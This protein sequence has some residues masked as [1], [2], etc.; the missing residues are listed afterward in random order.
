MFTHLSTFCD[1]SRRHITCHRAQGQTLDGTVSV[2]LGLENPDAR[3]PSDVASILYVA[4]TR[5]RRLQD[6]FVSPIFP[7]FWKKIAENQDIDRRQSEMA[8]RQ[9]SADLA[10]KYGMY[11]EMR[12]ELDWRPDYGDVDEEWRELQRRT[13]V[14]VSRRL[15]A[16][17]RLTKIPDGDLWTMR[18]DG[19]RV[20]ICLKA[21]TSE[22]HIGLDQGRRHFAIA[23][24]DQ[25]AGGVPQ[26]HYASVVNLELP[27][28]F[29]AAD[30]L[31][32]LMGSTNLMTMMQQRDPPA[33]C[34]GLR[35]VD[36]VIVHLEQMSTKNA[37][38]KQLGPELG[39][40]LQRH[41]AD[42]TTCIVK[43]SQ[44]NVHRASGPMF[45]L[46]ERVVKELELEPATY[47]KK[48]KSGMA[49][50]EANSSSG[51]QGG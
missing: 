25:V 8:L 51:Q 29:T 35:R 45:K 18:D 46:G 49:S 32:R 31:R 48:R 27:K 17:D 41:V 15:E 10:A 38:W 33:G 14:P 7:T 28:K 11:E 39:K 20:P 19:A 44:P 34:T 40:E 12:E 4:I 13:T 23:V 36:R 42:V 21:V 3:L 26:L 24:V 30:A 1:L 5:V 50:G 22:R 9:A 16:V 37:N 6:L 2:D 43:M 47:G